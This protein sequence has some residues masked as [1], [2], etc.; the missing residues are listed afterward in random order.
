VLAGLAVLSRTTALIPLIAFGV[1]LLAERRWRPLA[2]FGGIAAA[3]TAV[4]VAPFFLFDRANAMY[5]LVSWRGTAEIG[6]NSI[7]SLFRYAG[8]QA[9]SP[10]LYALDHFARR[11]DMYSVIAFVA[12][13]AYLAARRLRI[14]AYGRDAWAVLAIATLAV[15]MLSKTNWPYYYLEPFVFLLIWEFASMHDRRSGVWRWPVLTFGYLSVAATL[16]QFIGSQSVGELDRIVVGLLDFAAMLAFAIAVWLRAGAA[17]EDA[18]MLAGGGAPGRMA[19]GRNGAALAGAAG[20]P[21][22]GPVGGWSRGTPPPPSAQRPSDPRGA[23]GARAGQAGQ[24]PPR[25]PWPSGAANGA[26]TYE[27]APA[28]PPPGA[29]PASPQQQPGWAPPAQQTPPPGWMPPVPRNNPSPH[30]AANQGWSGGLG[31]PATPPTG[32]PNQPGAWDGSAG[33]GAPRDP[34]DPRDPRGG[35]WQGGPPAPPPANPSAPPGW[36][37]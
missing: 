9:A 27:G 36:G 29:Y 1:L 24:T 8:T 11:L 31:N 2:M 5:S 19:R 12:V 20:G 18:P 23:P 35:Q 13:V 25:Q 10:L 21:L 34:R 37:G 22:G 14:S 3:V 4:G 26:S 28:G 15:P 7:W 30:N 33:L 32:A 17:R 16:S 6:G